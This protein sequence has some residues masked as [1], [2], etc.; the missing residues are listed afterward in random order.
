MKSF[1]STPTNMGSVVLGKGL[2]P[3]TIMMEGHDGFTR[4]DKAVQQV[5]TVESGASVSLAGADVLIGNDSHF[6]SSIWMAV[7][8][9]QG[10]SVIVDLFHKVNHAVAISI[11]HAVQTICPRL[12]RLAADMGGDPQ[13]GLE[14]VCHVMY[15]MQ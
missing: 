12:Q 8:K 2:T 14:L 11:R 5:T 1:A 6:P 10:W 7:E 9:L 13:D 15:D 4:V 3:F